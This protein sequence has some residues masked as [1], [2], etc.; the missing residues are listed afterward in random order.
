MELPS[1]SPVEHQKTG[2]TAM[3]EQDPKVR[4]RNFLEVPLGYTP[5]LARQEASRCLLCKKPACIAGCPVNVDIPA[6][7]HLITQGNFAAA[8]RKIKE[9]NALPAV[10][11]R[12]CPQES[13]CESKCI[14]GKKFEPVAIGRCERFAADY[15]RTN[16]LVEIPPIAPKNGKKV[17]VIGAG[18][19]GL[20]VAGDIFAYDGF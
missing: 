18:P 3:P 5:E 12:V 13:Q 11:G 1:S 15:E 6:F 10:C 2:R 7:L 19:A 9:T 16:N 17:A 20:T 4:A 8:A 14:L